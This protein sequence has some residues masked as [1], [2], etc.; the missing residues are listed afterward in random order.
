MQGSNI[1]DNK[2][3]LLL[4]SGNAVSHVGLHG[5]RI[6]YPLLALI[7]TGSPVAA[8][9]VSFATMLPSL[10]F[11][12]PAGVVA[13]TWD[14]R[15]VLVMCQR[16]GLAATLLAAFIV[17][18][19]PPGLPVLL[20]AA[21]FIE[22]AA[23]VFFNTSELGLVRDVVTAEERPTALAFLEAEQ[24]IANMIGRLIGAATLS[25]ARTLPFLA[26]AASY[27]YCL[28]TLSRIRARIKGSPNIRARN[29][30]RVW[31]WNQAWAGVRSLWSEPFVRGATVILGITNAIFQIL[32]LSMTVEIRQGGHSTW[33]I[34][35]VL[36]A[37]G[38]GGLLG[39]AP[40]AAL[41]TR[42]APRALL[43]AMVWAWVVLSLPMAVDASPAVLALCWMGMGFVAPIGNVALA[44][45]RLRAF[46]EDLV[47]RIF[48]ATKLISHGGT[49]A[50]SL[51]A[52]ILLSTLGVS[53][54][55]WVILLG[56]VVMARSARRLPEARSAPGVPPPAAPRSTTWIAQVSRQNRIPDQ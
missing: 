15:R 43:T 5:V 6:A 41:A 4:W 24:P 14:R 39:A 16:S 10:L 23:Y 55:G 7:L 33:T 47:G 34:G 25:I 31:D 32:I 18:E 17:A 51:L 27:L 36:G 12:V 40:A 28:W 21:A 48:A 1:F 29:D 45:H 54:T 56:M 37:T 3:F 26:N 35:V 19:R 8:S 38:L 44:L 11:E 2:N 42:F 30:I 9:V 49:A 53:T 52:G 22:G 50:G 20:A 46:P 13:D